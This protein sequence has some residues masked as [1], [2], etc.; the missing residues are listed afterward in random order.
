MDHVQSS[1]KEDTV[2][3]QLHNSVDNVTFAVGQALTDPTDRAMQNVEDM[4]ERANRSVK[5]ALDSRGEIE[6]ISQL[7]DQLRESIEKFHTLQ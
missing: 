5:M 2:I 6:P 4:I 3:G 1:W 7:Q